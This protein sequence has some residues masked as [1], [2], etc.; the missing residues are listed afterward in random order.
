[1]RQLAKSAALAA[2]LVL[3]GEAASA[4]GVD[5]RI[6]PGGARIRERPTVVEERII[7]RPARSRTVCRTE[8]RERVTRGG[9]IIRRPVEVCRQVVRSF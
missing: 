2:I 5:I 9:V 4:Q 6:G 7:R 3:S 8:I 1:M